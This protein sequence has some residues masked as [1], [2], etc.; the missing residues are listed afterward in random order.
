[1]TVKA[2]KD[3]TYVIL[4][5]DY[6]VSYLPEYS[7]GRLRFDFQNTTSTPGDL[8]LNQ[9]P[10]FSSASWKGSTLT[11]ELLDDGSFLGY[12]AY[13]ENGNIVLRFNNPTGIEG[14]RIT[15]DPGHGGSDPGVA[16]DIDPNWPEKRIN[17]ELS[18]AIAQELEDRG[19]KVNLLNTYNNTTSLDS[20]LAQAKNFD[21]S[22]FLCIHTNSS[23]TNSAVSY[24]F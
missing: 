8:S 24:F 15:V 3:F 12:K 14:A 2:N 7:S 10:L 23:E 13:H 16:D 6:P 4:Q 9:N 21:S 19:A 1:M 18:K 20:R 22:L 17:W 5:S 11:L